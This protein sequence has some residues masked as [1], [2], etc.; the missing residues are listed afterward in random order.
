[1]ELIVSSGCR[2]SGRDLL[3]VQLA[4]LAHDRHAR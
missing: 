1:M 2:L 4:P 3:L